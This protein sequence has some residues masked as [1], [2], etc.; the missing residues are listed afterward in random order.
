MQLHRH[1]R[2]DEFVR[3]HLDLRASG[4]RLCLAHCGVEFPAGIDA[5]REPAIAAQRLRQQVVMPLRKIVVVD[6]RVLAE[7]ALDQIAI[8]VQKEDDRFQAATVKLA[9]LLRGEERRLAGMPGWT[10][11][12]QGLYMDTLPAPHRGEIVW[13]TARHSHSVAHRDIAH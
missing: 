12:V 9:H 5:R 10:W 1:R 7:Q 3:D 11:K 8:V 13:A 6:V 2:R 4:A